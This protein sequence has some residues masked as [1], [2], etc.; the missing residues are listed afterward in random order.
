MNQVQELAK[1]HRD[2]SNGNSAFSLLEH[3]RGTSIAS[4]VEQ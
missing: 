4:K 3:S 1:T 2:L